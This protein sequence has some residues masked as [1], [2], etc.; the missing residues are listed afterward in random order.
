MVHDGK[1]LDFLNS[2]TIA[3]FYTY[4]KRKKSKFNAKC[5]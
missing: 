5:P 4:I 1:I 2:V 3:L